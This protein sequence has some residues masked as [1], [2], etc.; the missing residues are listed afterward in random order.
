MILTKWTNAEEDVAELQRRTL[1]YQTSPNAIVARDTTTSFI[2]IPKNVKLVDFLA[3]RLR[4]SPGKIIR[5]KMPSGASS[6]VFLSISRD[7]RRYLARELPL[8]LKTTKSVLRENKRFDDEAGEVAL[9]YARYLQSKSHADQTFADWVK[10]EYQQERDERATAQEKERQEEQE[11]KRRRMIDKVRGVIDR[12]DWD[13]VSTSWASGTRLVTDDDGRYEFTAWNIA[14]R[15]ICIRV[16]DL[17]CVYFAWRNDD[18]TASREVFGPIPDFGEAPSE[19]SFR[20]AVLDA[21][22]V[23]SE[24]DV[25]VVVTNIKIEMFDVTTLLPLPDSAYHFPPQ[26]PCYFASYDALT[27]RLF[28]VL[29]TEVYTFSKGYVAAVRDR[30]MPIVV[31]TRMARISSSVDTDLAVFGTDLII[32]NYREPE[33]KW[34]YAHV[35]VDIARQ[36]GILRQTAEWVTSSTDVATETMRVVHTSSMENGA[37]HVAFQRKSSVLSL[38]APD[39]VA[40]MIRQERGSLTSSLVAELQIAA[41][42]QHFVGFTMADVDVA[43]LLRVLL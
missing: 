31:D 32:A 8:R 6:K 23:Y 5:A 42:R 11:A 24:Q 19:E 38:M 34:Q 29:D 26:H 15:G 1:C 4:V 39:S 14:N 22:L 35:Y 13:S 40:M 16:P 2:S 28:C 41:R 3:D 25:I 9:R 37:V 21:V 27:T 30:D 12:I 33:Q 17:E 7:G 43:S 18:G 10:R 36:Q 20:V